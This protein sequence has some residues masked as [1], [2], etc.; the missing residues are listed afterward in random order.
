[1]VPLL[2]SLGVSWNSNASSV[3]MQ[4]PPLGQNY[5]FGCVGP[6]S[7]KKGEETNSTGEYGSFVDPPS[8][9]EAQLKDR[10]F[11]FKL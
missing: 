3:V 6:K 4:D 1:M 8:L 10:G 2:T 7:K 5:C 9:F 11:E